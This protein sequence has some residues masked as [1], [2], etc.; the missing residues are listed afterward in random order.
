MAT[1]EE[2]R[3]KLLAQ[4]ARSERAG[5]G[6]GDRAVYAFWNLPDN[7]S[8]EI[9][10]LPD[11]NANNTFFWVER[12]VIRLPFQ[13]VVGETD[14]ETTVVV[15]C[16][17]MYG[18]TCPVLA[19]TRPWWKDPDLQETARKYWK[20]RSYIF[21]GFVVKDGLN[22]KEVPENPIRRFVINPSI[23]DIIK[24]SLM[25]PEM[26]DLPT[27]YENGRDFNLIKTKKGKW[28]DYGTSKWKMKTRALSETEAE[29]VARFS[30]WDLKDFL[31]KKPTTE[32]LE[33][34]KD[35]FRASVDG[36]AYDPNKWGKFY[37]PSNFKAQNA[38][39]SAEVA[40][41][42]EVDAEEQTAPTPAPAAK[43]VSALEK[44]RQA[45]KAQASVAEEEAKPAVVSSEKKGDPAK[46]LEL[47]RSKSANK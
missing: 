24:S 35:M 5:T 3:Q 27:D 44:L 37:K 15:P 42:G 21:Q 11:G 30:L 2:I 13:G 33:A 6:G 39:A 19:E 29:A 10:F 28:A 16:M 40:E 17:E 20:K 45:S 38:D 36:E 25:D 26:E 4:Q 47:I 32:E 43:P 31:P 22:E 12:L 23:F 46:I 18:E 14:K 8:S 41:V 1:L 9:R 7:S 34:I